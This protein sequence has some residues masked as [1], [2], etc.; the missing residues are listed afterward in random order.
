MRPPPPP[1]GGGAYAGGPRPRP[2]VSVMLPTY[3]PDALL[4]DTLRSVLAQAPPAEEM[5]IAVVDDGPALTETQLSRLSAVLGPHAQQD[6]RQSGRHGLGLQIVRDIAT[7]IGADLAVR[8]ASA[9]HGLRVEVT[10]R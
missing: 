9:G 5:Q 2:R 7:A 8:R 6:R 10:L 4:V 3:R 1:A